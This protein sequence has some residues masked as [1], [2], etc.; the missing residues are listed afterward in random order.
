MLYS[1]VV[2][3]FPEGDVV[4]PATLG[5]HAHAALLGMVKQVDEGLAQRVHDGQGEKPFT[6][7]PLQGRFE[8]VRKGL[9]GL[10]A[11]GE[12]WLRFT[13]LSDELYQAVSRFFLESPSPTVRLGEGRFVVARVTAS[14]SAECG[15]RSAESDTPNSE[16]RTPNSWGGYATFGGLWEQ[17]QSRESVRVRFYSPTCFRVAAAGGSRNVAEPNLRL[18]A[19]SWLNRWNRFAPPELFFN[20]ERLLDFVEAC[21]QLRKVNVET[22]M[23]DFGRYLQKGFVG[24]VEWAVSCERRMTFDGLRAEYL[25]RE[26]DALAS[27]AFFSGTGYKTAMGMGQTRQA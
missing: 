9:V 5:R 17:A 11:G 10:K 16:F 19:Q 25:L 20:G 24:R 6:V 13:F 3:L 4:L 7:S 15:V 26:L 1:L 2:Q 22:K 21:G 27:F 23:L 12:Y 18:C 14:A 8:R